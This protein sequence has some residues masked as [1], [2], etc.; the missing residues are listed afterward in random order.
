VGLVD[1]RAE[2]ERLDRLLAD[3][4][5]GTSGTLVVRGDAGVGKSALLDAMVARAS[6][7]RVVRAGGVESEMELPFAALHLLCAPFT[8]RFERLPGPQRDALS[9]AFGLRVGA[10][11]DR[12]L[13]GLAVLSLLSDVAE[14]QPLVCVVDDAQWLDR[15]SAQVLGFVAR[16]VAAEAVVIVFAV[17]E[18]WESNDL[19]G[20][21]EL[22][23]GPLADADARTVLA[24]A[25]PGRLDASVRDRI[26][27][28]A[29][30]NPLALLELPRAWTAAGIAGGFGLPAGVSVS[31]RIEESFRRRLAP[32]PDDSRRLLLIAAADPAGDASVIWA[33]AG[34]LGISAESAVPAAT[35]G[36]LDDGSTLRF[37]HPLVRS[38]VYQDAP[39]GDRRLVHGALARAT[40]PEADPDRRVWHLATAA[41]GPDEDV[42]AE[43]ER[44]AGRAQARGGVAAAAAFLRRAVELTRDPDRRADRALAAAQAS[45]EA[46]GTETA[47]GLLKT[48]ES[49]ATSEFQRARVDLL[50]GHA[51]MAAFATD[52]PAVLLQAGRRLEPFSVDLA[53]QT[54]LIAFGAA[55]LGGREDV[56]LEIARAVQDLA[57]SDP[58]GP[59]DLLV[60]GV[61]RLALEGPA[62]A[63]P[64]LRRAADATVD[65]PL[66]DVMQWGWAAV[67]ASDYVWDEG[68]ER[69]M[70]ERQIRLLRD[71]GALAHLP[72]LLSALGVATAS[73]GDFAG[74]AALIAE[75]QAVAAATGSPVLPYTALRV[76]ALR[77]READAL[78]MITAA[79]ERLSAVGQGLAERQ[80]QGAAA[81]LYNGLGR[82]A[83]ALSAARAAVANRMDFPSA[84]L[85]LPELVE[86]AARM[87]DPQT[88]RDAF[89][90]LAAMTT[91]SATDFALGIEARARALVSD[92]ASAEPLYRE[93]IERLG[94]TEL[95]PDLGRSHLVYG[96]WL[97]R[98]G[99]RVDAR[100]Q[101]RTAHD[102]LASIGMEAF[103]QRARR[104][105][106]AT[107]ESVRK[108][109]VETADD[110]TPQ[111][112]QIARLAGEGRTNPEIGAE[113]FLSPR[114]VEWHLRKVFAKLGV[115]SRRELRAALPGAARMVA[116]V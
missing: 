47:L 21:P 30:G 81:I 20:L 54:Y 11:P 64:I 12:F 31:G 65:L 50:R 59:L 75:G 18:P 93:A 78:P 110:L 56:G 4:R 29:R 86:A 100:A 88:A 58:P 32:L 82:Y 34:E 57:P 48:A 9:T 74:A 33:A 104:E 27:A 51:S 16:R 83:E 2:I 41:A 62:S 106:L 69:V 60:D 24:S 84:M 42:A 71:A 35:A 108:R 46:G 43:L 15:A 109:S 23:V 116:H 89:A 10:P 52:S 99:R 17:R 92:G 70:L 8:D 73:T 113:L 105:L 55:T 90:R 39:P 67:A 6:G 7:C 114:T 49:V 68:L 14:S 66:Q 26:V 97:R 85:A 5:A 61:T 76:A 91:P 102:L 112:L 37:R 98:Q 22:T 96:E 79:I 87:D 53:R 3:A 111:E 38:V 103:V 95:R 44:S 72:I 45:L 36:L 28:E 101:L 107:G 1:R 40:D 63:I 115:A 19:V 25:I 13:V 77:G 94:H 80:A